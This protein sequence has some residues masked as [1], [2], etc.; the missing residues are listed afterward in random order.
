MTRTMTTSRGDTITTSMTDREAADLILRTSRSTFGKD[1]AER[2]VRG[3][4]LS[5][6]QLPWLHKIALESLLPAT[7]AVVAT[8]LQL[9][10]IV[11]LMSNAARNLRFPKVRFALE[12][13]TLQLSIAGERSRYAGQV[14]V[15]DGGRYP[16]NQ[17]YGS[18][19]ATEFN[20]SRRCPDWVIEALTMLE[21]NPAQYAAVYGQRTGSCCFCRRELTD[22]RSVTV[23]YGPICADHYGLPWGNTTPTMPE[24][25]AGVAA[26]AFAPDT[27]G[28][29]EEASESCRCGHPNCGFCA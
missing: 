29:V 2:L 1:L 5:D 13:G 6:K 18:I 12:A 9:P 26:D 22:A 20:R 28:D 17:F 19:S 24:R 11:A 4:R 21:A 3:V 10:A 7:P 23:G 15:T 25:L 27:T 16:D 8:A 14:M